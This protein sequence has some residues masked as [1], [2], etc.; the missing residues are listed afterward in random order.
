[1]L[2]SSFDCFP[3]SN[4]TIAPNPVFHA[5]P[6]AEKT[7]C[8][9]PVG[10]SQKEAIKIW[11]IPESIVIASTDRKTNLNPGVRI[12]APGT[13]VGSNAASVVL[14]LLGCSPLDGVADRGRIIE[15][16]LGEVRDSTAMVALLANT[17]LPAVTR[18]E[19]LSAF[20]K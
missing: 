14:T 10:V 7:S 6:I 18:K 11:A 13:L 12:I 20:N 3:P 4:P 9:S 2:G 1:M 17:V 5:K 8:W 19:P 16:S 15:L